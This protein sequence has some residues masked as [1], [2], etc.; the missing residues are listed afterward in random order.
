MGLHAEVAFVVVAVA[1]VAVVVAVTVGVVA[2]DNLSFQCC[3][4]QTV[5]KY[6]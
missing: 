4:R 2:A 1:A 5:A 3:K 6:A